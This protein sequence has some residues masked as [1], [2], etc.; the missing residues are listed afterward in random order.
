MCLLQSNYLDS[1]HFRWNYYC[2]YKAT[3]ALFKEND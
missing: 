3:I 1:F 2:F